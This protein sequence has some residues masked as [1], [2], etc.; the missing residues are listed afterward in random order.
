MRV[1]VG[2]T[3]HT[4][5]AN[6]NLTDDG[7]TTFGYDTE[8]RP[9]GVGLRALSHLTGRTSSGILHYLNHN[10]YV[11]IGPGRMPASGSLPAGPS[12]PRVSVGPQRPGFD[13][14]HLDLRIRP[15]D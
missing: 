8:N 3:N 4:W 11:R 1:N 12:V 2:G 15:I 9:S 5:D 13:N 7:P 6:G 14:P 10:P